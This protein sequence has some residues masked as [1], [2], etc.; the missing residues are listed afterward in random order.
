MAFF[1]TCRSKEAMINK[2][3]ILSVCVQTAAGVFRLKV[4]EDFASFLFYFF[5]FSRCPF[6]LDCVEKQ[7]K[8][9]SV[10][11]QCQEC[12]SRNLLVP[13][14]F[15]FFL[16]KIKKNFAELPFGNGYND[17]GHVNLIFVFPRIF[18]CSQL[19]G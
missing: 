11:L 1:L 8:G 3:R 18:C 17:H 15:F 7:V 16:C 14:I 5:V 4:S 10:P 2:S 6:Y 12:R 9:N 19:D 13:V